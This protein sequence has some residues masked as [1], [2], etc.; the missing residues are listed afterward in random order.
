MTGAWIVFGVCL[1]CVLYTF[2]GYPLL[3][4][5]WAL[6]R[7]RP[8]VKGSF[9]GSFTI[10]LAAHNEERN[11]GRRVEDLRRQIGDRDGEILVIADGCTDDTA[12]LAERFMDG[13]APS[14]RVLAWPENRGKAAALSAAAVEARGE[15]LFF[16]DARQTWA[17][18]ALTQM[19]G[20]FADPQVGAVS[21][22]LVLESAP[23]VL[24]GVGLY[25][26][27]EKWLRGRESRVWSQVGV[28]GAIAA[29]RRSLFRL[30]PAGTLLDDVYW[31][32]AIAMDGHRVVH[33]A[34][35]RAFDRLP[36]KSSAEFR[37]KVRT[38]AG[39]YQLAA[40]LPASLA[41]WRNPV[42]LAWV[43]HKLARLAAPW[44]LIGL[45][46]S[47]LVLGEPLMHAFAAVQVAGYVAGLFGLM[48]NRSRLLS[49]AGS[50]LV[51]NA[52]AWCAF[53]VWLLGRTG[54]A[55]RKVEYNVAAPSHATPEPAAITM[56]HGCEGYPS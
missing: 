4:G 25:W 17:D 22:D 46:T 32:L 45:L 52:A 30:I 12:R 5:L 2:A 14:V 33:D 37:R 27:F 28:T 20:N 29:G 48:T 23:G 6:V 31:P 21:G 39:N 19:L 53:W 47:A 54:S 34:T 9:H 3:L 11:I 38:L 49:A 8:V 10:L 7:A 15:I 55:W 16:A 44:A 18:D 26:R 56:E 42:W 51:L 13:R 43:S 36:E 41:P 40:L 35:A 1:A 24:A 50:F